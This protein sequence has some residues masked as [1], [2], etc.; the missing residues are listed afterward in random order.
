MSSLA[1]LFAG[2]RT[3]SR[4]FAKIVKPVPGDKYQVVDGGGRYF[5]VSS[6]DDWRVGAWVTVMQGVIVGAGQMTVP[7]TV[8]EV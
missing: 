7:G 5:T 8:F 2:S 4:V 3:Q 1:E 6:T